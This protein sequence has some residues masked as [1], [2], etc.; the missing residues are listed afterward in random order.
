MNK[1]ESST[2]FLLFCLTASFLAW[3]LLTPIQNIVYFISDDAYYYYKTALNIISGRGSS[4]DGLNLTNGYHPLWM[5]IILPVFKF[6]ATNLDTPLRIVLCIQT[7]AYSGSIILCWVYAKKLF[8]INVAIVSIAFLT[9]FASPLVLSLN[10]LESTFLLFWVF[11]LLYSDLKFQ[12][13]D[14]H[15]GFKK[16]VVLGFLFAVLVLIRLDNV[17]IIIAV[18]ILK[19]SDRSLSVT[20]LA[21]TRLLITNFWPT[22]VIFLLFISPYFIW[23]Q[24][25]FGHLT[26]ISGALKSTFPIPVT[27]NHMGAHAL[28][29][30][31]PYIALIV[32][33]F[34]DFLRKGP[35]SRTYSKLSSKYFLFTAIFTGN[36]IHL[37]WTQFF[38][39][40]GVYQ[41]HFTSYVPILAISSAIFLLNTF[42]K[43]SPSQKTQH[44]VL[45][46]TICMS[47]AYNWVLHTEKG[48]HHK[49]RIEAALWARDNT[50]VNTVFALADAGAFSY[51]SERP[52]INLDGL[53]NSYEFQESISSGKLFE[54]LRKNQTKYFADAFTKCDY[55][56]SKEKV[57]AYPGK[58]IAKPVGYLLH[59][60]KKD[61]RFRSQP[62]IYR[63]TTR[64][65]KICFVIWPF[66]SA[67]FQTLP[68]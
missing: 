40:W 6:S 43:I 16:A 39:A 49:G 2:F 8:S 44:S 41:W 15:S 62:S 29:Y 47:V 55:S 65:E 61:E 31:I 18:T 21:R 13:S 32:W 12:L 58:N 10:G 52:V 17:F 4:F 33:F 63:P 42:K 68:R 35:S 56:Q 26:P 38:M 19:L 54:F 24:T 25:T 20:F 14:S 11:L 59:F 36:S 50:P 5:I 57:L 9:I 28:P 37:L 1:S 30:V 3:I 67:K 45:F 64:N 48:D 51:F 23:N 27:H 46:I 22:F 34:T 53:I 60:D 7:I 66:T